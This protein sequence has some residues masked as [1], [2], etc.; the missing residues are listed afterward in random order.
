MVE[1]EHVLWVRGN[2]PNEAGTPRIFIQEEPKKQP[3]R[4]AA[5]KY[6]SKPTPP[7]RSQV[8]VVEIPNAEFDFGMEYPRSKVVT[9]KATPK[10]VVKATPIKKIAT[11]NFPEIKARSYPVARS[12]EEFDF[13]M[14]LPEKYKMDKP[15]VKIPPCRCEAVRQ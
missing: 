15:N 2:Q 9:T 4:K 13:G 12:I 7:K 3:K 14:E 1:R 5:P 11:P 8:R 6:K 10:P